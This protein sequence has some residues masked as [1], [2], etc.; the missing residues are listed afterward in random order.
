M[1]IIKGRYCLS[2]RVQKRP[3]YYHCYDCDVCVAGYDHHCPWTGKCIGEG[4][5]R[6]F[7]K[8]ICLT[9]FNCTYF[10]VVVIFKV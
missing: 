8:F 1:F 5:I 9:F 7:N 2:C 4:N 3:D 6:L 10:I